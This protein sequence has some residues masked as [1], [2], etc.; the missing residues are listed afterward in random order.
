MEPSDD[1]E[2]QAP[3][4]SSNLLLESLMEQ[5]PMP[6]ATERRLRLVIALKEAPRSVIKWLMLLRCPLSGNP[7]PY[8]KLR[9]LRR[10]LTCIDSEK[11]R[12][13]A[14]YTEICIMLAK[15]S[16]SERGVRQN[17][18]EMKKRRVGEK[19]PLRYEEEAAFEYEAGNKEAAEEILERGVDNDAL[20]S[21]QKKELLKR[22]IAGRAGWVMAFSG[23]PQEQKVLAL[24]TRMQALR[25][26]QDNNMTT[27]MQNE[28][29][30]HSLR[31]SIHMLMTPSNTTPVTHSR[32][33][34]GFTT[35]FKTP[36]SGNKSPLLTTPLLPT[37][38]SHKSQSTSRKPATRFT[39]GGPPLR[40]IA[41]NCDDEDEN[42]DDDDAMMESQTTPTMP[43]K[44]TASIECREAD[45]T[46]SALPAIKSEIVPKPK[47]DVGDISHILKWN[48]DKNKEDRG[49]H[50]GSKD[51]K[52]LLDK[53]A[54]PTE[55]TEAQLKRSVEKETTKETN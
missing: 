52:V 38:S 12:E 28:D 5:L 41:T 9:L 35:V 18:Q 49:T 39:L 44:P 3:N 7:G 22:V 51:T 43:N 53:F 50:T 14:E 8:N 1:K 30:M 10:A 13:T 55:R 54:K 24:R 45:K 47:I 29:G 19:Q 27:R 31:G 16:D 37:R 42:D 34:E 25:R 46:I 17:F 23:S 48:P 2:N 33:G 21:M 15:L 11:A 40:V 36:R 32:N 20:T 26:T 4:A 6:T